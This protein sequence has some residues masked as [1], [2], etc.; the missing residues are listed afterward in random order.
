MK[1]LLSAIFAV[2]AF[3]GAYAQAGNYETD[4]K[5]AEEAIKKYAFKNNYK[6]FITYAEVKDASVAVTPTTDYLIFY[7]YNNSDHPATTFKGYLM[8]PDNKLKA[9][10][11]AVPDD[12]G[13]TGLARVQ[14]LKFTTPKFASGKDKLPVKLEASPAATIY[15]FYRK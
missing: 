9:K 11:S 6:Y 12:I 15:V 5:T 4:G 7:V 13:Q 14:R 8:T 2:L 1:K 10:Y 3:A